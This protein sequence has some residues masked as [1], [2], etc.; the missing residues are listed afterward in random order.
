MGNLYK[1]LLAYIYIYIYIYVWIFINIFIYMLAI[2]G[3]TARPNGLTFFF[4]NGFFLKFEIFFLWA[5]PSTSAS[6]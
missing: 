3:Q 1:K 2:A 4:K 5:T 6:I